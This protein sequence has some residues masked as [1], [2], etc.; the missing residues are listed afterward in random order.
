MAFHGILNAFQDGGITGSGAV[1]VADQSNTA[2]GIGADDTDGAH[3][4]HIQRQ[5]AVILQQDAAL[6][7]C[8]LGQSQMLITFHS[9]VGDLIEFAALAHD[10]QQVTGGEQALSGQGN[11]LFGDQTFLESLHHVQVSI[12]AV[13]VAAHFQCQ[14]SGLR[15]SL[16]DHMTFVEVTNGPAVGDH[17]ALKA[18]FAA[19][20]IHQQELTA[21][22]GLAVG[23]VV[24][25]HDRFCL[26]IL[27]AGLEGIEV[28]FLHILGIGFRIEAVAQCLGAT[29]DRQMLGTGSGLHDFAFALEATDIGLAQP[30]GQVRIFAIGFMAAT[31][32]G[33][34]ENIDIGRPEG[35]ALINVTVFFLCKGIVLCAAFR[36]GYITQPLQQHIV[37]H[38]S[39]ADGLG[40]AGCRTGTGNT[41]QRLIPPVV[42]GDAQTG[43]GRGIIAQ[44]ADFFFNGHLRNQCPC[45]FKSFR[46]IH[47]HCSLIF[48]IGESRPFDD[49][50]PHL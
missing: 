34:A 27:D 43:N 2:V 6:S 31:P 25:T 49:V 9:F 48:K 22:A 45:F 28:G 29:V 35:Q 11:L 47:N 50:I 8:F 20:L 32:A 12:A 41:M 16:G 39:H 1:I 42:G 17:M 37:E 46:T 10:T 19:D 24:S 26:G 23:S 15:G 18:P 5:Q 33:I 4:L 13:Q 44:L 38:S 40:E 14:G 30:C 36:C 7:A 3:L 21:A